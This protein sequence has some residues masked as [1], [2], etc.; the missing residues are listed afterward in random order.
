MQNLLLVNLMRMGDILQMT[1]LIQALRQNRPDA[2]ISLLLNEAFVDVADRID[3]DAVLPF[4]V[5]SLVGAVSEKESLVQSY[6]H[7]NGYGSHT[8]SFLNAARRFAGASSFLASTVLSPPPR[9]PHFLLC[10]SF[11]CAPIAFCSVPNSRL[12]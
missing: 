1:P 12:R 6:R 11:L 4:P 2:R 3:V 9:V 7:V 5:R 8:Y 10:S